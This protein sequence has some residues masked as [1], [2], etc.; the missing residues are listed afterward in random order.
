[1]IALYFSCHGLDKRHF[2]MVKLLST[3]F[4]LLSRLKGKF[5]AVTDLNVL[6]NIENPL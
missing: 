5:V 6:F 2:F 4:V 3:K 1:M